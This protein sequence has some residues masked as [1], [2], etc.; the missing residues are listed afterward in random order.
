MCKIFI[1]VDPVTLY[2]IKFYQRS[3]KIRSKR[4][5]KMERKMKCVPVFCSPSIYLSEGLGYYT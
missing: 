1:I 2:L 3:P 4:K 5:R